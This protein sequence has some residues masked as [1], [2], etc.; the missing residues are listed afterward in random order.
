MTAE[1]PVLM[2]VK[3]NI[4]TL[5]LNRPA[6]L[7]ALNYDLID[8]FQQHLDA[9]E[10][11]DTIRIVILT[12]AGKAFSA[13]AD[14]AGFSSSVEAGMT[15][16]MREFVGRGQA[17]TKRIE[18]FPRPI[19]AAVNGLAFG[20]GCEVVEACPLAISSDHARFAKPEINLGFP[21][22]F[23]GTQRLP[24]HIGRKR[25]LQL[26]L[27]GDSISAEE[28]GRIGLIN[29]VVP[30]SK[31]MTRA[32]ELAARIIEKPSAA[33]TASLASVTR[34]INLSIDEGLAVEANQFA[35]MVPTHDIRE[36]I[37]AFLERRPAQ[38]NGR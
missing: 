12:G 26:I 10:R 28:A 38:F 22:P 14:I 31:L 8:A 13:G 20:G 18:N 4:A 35:Q 25:A 27:T 11:D 23:G 2:S 9:I 19:I 7:N 34:G 6:K 21:P 29:E 17:F 36:G 33:V 15:I 24:R 1:Q 16:A 37:N 3:D 30:A 5:T 32:N